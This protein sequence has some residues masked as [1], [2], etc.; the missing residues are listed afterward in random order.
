MS[1]FS[2]GGEK[3][4]ERRADIE[5][6]V[7]IAHGADTSAPRRV[8]PG[9]ILP[10]D[11]GKICAFVD[12][13]DRGATVARRG[14]WRSLADE[15]GGVNAIVSVIPNSDRHLGTVGAQQVWVMLGI[16]PLTRVPPGDGEV[17]IVAQFP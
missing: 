6:N 1:D 16:E 10:E 14:G 13:E 15:I 2:D 3:P 9:K 11:G 4:V 8:G 12:L 17:A 5:F 7:S